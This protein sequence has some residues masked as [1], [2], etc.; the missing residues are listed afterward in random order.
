VAP[1][2]IPELLASENDLPPIREQLATAIAIAARAYIDTM[3]Q[4][5]DSRAAH[6]VK[7]L[8]EQTTRA[9]RLYA[10]SR[11]RA[12]DDGFPSV[13]I[14]SRSRDLLYDHWTRTGRRRYEARLEEWRRKRDE[15][16]AEWRADDEDGDQEAPGDGRRLDLET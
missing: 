3:E 16:E 5:P 4:Q 7:G 2:Y 9:V 11:D 15:A 1:F 13:T 6:E 12:D 8:F 10:L 14:R